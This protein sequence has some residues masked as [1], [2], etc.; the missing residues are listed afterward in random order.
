MEEIK[1]Y[2]VESED[3]QI[4][5]AFFDDELEA[6][7]EKEKMCNDYTKFRFSV[8]PYTLLSRPKLSWPHYGIDNQRWSLIGS[9]LY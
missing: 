8:K 5:S 4:V 3:H 6:K 1:I 9:I 2:R 7:A